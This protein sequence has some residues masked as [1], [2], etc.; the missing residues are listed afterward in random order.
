MAKDVF[1]TLSSVVPRSIASGGVS[2]RARPRRSDRPLGRDG[3]RL[4]AGVPLFA[5]LSRR[6]LKKVAEHADV[7]EFDERDAIV[8]EGQR[9][10]TF[11]V[12]LE[13]EAKVLRRGRAAGRLG[14]GEFFGEVSLLDGGP[15]TASVVAATPITAI[16]IFKRSF[17]RVVSEE[18]A[19][20][21]KILAVVAR[22]LRDA[23]RSISQ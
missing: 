22:R 20:A 13:G 6:N 1:D 16:R 12:L 3:L 11:Y 9:G 23:E 4:L 17:D 15:R 5:G 10:G 14:P 2:E 7:V 8:Q 19:V 21:T 18:P